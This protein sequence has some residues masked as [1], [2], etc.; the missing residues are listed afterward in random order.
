MDLIDNMCSEITFKINATFSR[1]HCVKLS[2][3]CRIIAILNI[4]H[5]EYD[6]ARDITT[7]HIYNRPYVKLL[8]DTS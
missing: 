6:I 3:L 2:Y 7:T 1:G 5:I 4:T 8:K